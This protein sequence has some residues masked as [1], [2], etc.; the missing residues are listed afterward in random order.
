[1]YFQLVFQ[2]IKSL[3][4]VVVIFI[5][6]VQLILHHVT[7]SSTVSSRTIKHFNKPASN[8]VSTNWHSVDYMGPFEHPEKANYNISHTQVVVMHNVSIQ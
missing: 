3:R 7:V 2:I 1:M 4:N 6:N 5:Q 8:T